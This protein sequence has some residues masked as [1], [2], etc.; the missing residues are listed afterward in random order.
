[1]RNN[2]LSIRKYETCPGYGWDVEEIMKIMA[3]T[4]IIIYAIPMIAISTTVFMRQ[5]WIGGLIIFSWGGLGA[6][7]GIHLWRKGEKDERK[8]N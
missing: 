2:K 4:L 7:C 1:M 6:A 8:R 5:D 3:V